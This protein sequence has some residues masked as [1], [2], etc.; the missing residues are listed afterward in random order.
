MRR[1]LPLVFLAVTWLAYAAWVLSGA[2]AQ[3]VSWNDGF[4]GLFPVAAAV[5]TLVASRR[6]SLS[7]DA[8][9][10][11]RWIGTGMA[12]NC[13]SAV[14]WFILDRDGP[15]VTLPAWTSLSYLMYY[16]CVTYGLTRFAT[17]RRLRAEAR[18]GWLDGAIV[19]TGLVAGGWYLSR[20]VTG[21][22][23]GVSLA[24]TLVNLTTVGCDFF[25][26]WAA[27]TIARE[28][29]DPES[30]IA[31]L[32]LAAATLVMALADLW[33]AL[34]QLTGRY[35]SGAPVDAVATLG[36]GLMA[37]S[38]CCLH[39]ASHPLPTPPERPITA[40][41]SSW[42]ILAVVG[43]LVL[44]AL[45]IAQ[46]GDG[47][48]GVLHTALALVVALEFARQWD[49]RRQNRTLAQSQTAADA[50][51]RSLVQYSH[52]MT[53][54][55][56][57][58][59]RILYAS[60]SALRQLGTG[61]VTL[62]N[63]DLLALVH[64]ADRARFAQQLSDVSPASLP[65]PVTWRMG[66]DG[67]WRDVEGILSD[68]SADPTVGGI[69]LNVRDVSE[70]E[71]LEAQLRQSQKMDAV[72]RL[73][74]GIAH[75]FN[76]ILAAVMA[77][78]QLLRETTD[79]PEAVD[80]EDAARRGAALTRQLLQ[81]SRGEAPAPGPVPVAEVVNGMAPMLRR[82]I[83]RDIRLDFTLGPT[84]AVVW[85]DRGQL[86]QVVLNLV[87]NARDAMPE[88]GTLAV[89]T[90]VQGNVACLE[91]RDSGHG[92]DAETRAR[93]FEPFFTTKPRGR[94]TGLGLATV[95]GIVSKAGGDIEVES[96]PGKGTTMRVRLPLAAEAQRAD[97]A[98]DAPPPREPGKLLL[99]V[100]DED[101]LRLSI[102]RFLERRG[103][104][105]LVARDGLE[106]LATL[107]DAQWRV[108]L[109][110]TDIVMPRMGGIE[111]AGKVR[112]R[113][114]GPVVLCMTGHAGRTLEAP[115][116]APWHPDRVMI[117]PFELNDLAERV[118]QLL[119]QPVG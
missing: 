69:V 48:L 43:L 13:T 14:A 25:V 68:L 3:H 16:P 47:D 44:V 116:D 58:A 34:W 7:P 67:Q 52:D 15:I 60:P 102:S 40:R 21:I 5:S 93:A 11:W 30:R 90:D 36:Y 23:T 50:R 101:A 1:D 61:L 33:L 65:T 95:Y 75:D 12:F 8:R 2:A 66:A 88:G 27:S 81:F 55:C 86:E 37:A 63:G 22:W 98:P 74:G 100:D 59:G 6:A 62:S 112:E 57:R 18:R 105:V 51:F 104:R 73:A 53:F 24:D 109:V 119:A 17:A 110:L 99:V 31:M 79:G 113:A 54:V 70:R 114:G 71:R 45:E 29:Q 39:L 85:V 46:S 118:A 103:Y 32:V 111:L 82:L 78:A 56:D 107:E 80:I 83:S 87:V 26:V 64:P 97:R 91:V 72:G 89:S 92:M 108:D 76:N 19:A 117:K 41:F 35:H 106:A 20:S 9:E 38:A 94:G 42:P 4:F 77:N 28:E 115:V 84:D 10:G 96:A 49:V